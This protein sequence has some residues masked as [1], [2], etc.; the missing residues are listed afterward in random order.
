MFWKAFRGISG[1]LGKSSRFCAPL[2]PQSTAKN[3]IGLFHRPLPG[4]NRSSRG[5]LEVTIR[6]VVMMRIITKSRSFSSRSAGYFTGLLI[7]LVSGAASARTKPPA[8]PIMTLDDG[9]QLVNLARSGMAEFIKSRTPADK[10]TLPPEMKHL[11]TRFRPVSITLRSSGKLMA[12]SIRAD[13]NV[14]RSVLAAALDA[15]RSS[16]LPDRVTPAVLAA[17]TVEIEVLGPARAVS[18][19]ELGACIV[20]GLTGVRVSRGA[21]KK[22]VLPSTTCQLGLSALQTHVSCLA[23]LP[24]P[25]G[26]KAKA[27]AWSVFGSKHY[28]GYPDAVVVQLFRGKILIPPEGL[29]DE[30]LS[31]A[32]A[33]AGLF[34]AR[35]QDPNGMYNMPNRKP[36]LHEHLHATYAMA[37]LSRRDS[38]KLF[39]VSVNRAMAY[40]ARFVLADKKQARVLARSSPGRTAES[41]TRATAWLLLAI[42]ELPAQAANKE[43]A[44]KLARALRQDVVSV[45]GPDHGLTTPGQLLD[46]SVALM[47]LRR[48]LPKNESNAKLLDPMRKTMRAWSKSGQKLS[49]L[50]FRGTGTM[51]SLPK[52]R[53]IDDSDLPDRRGGFVSSGVE[54]TT[55][56]TAIAA[57]CLAEAIESAG[58]SPDDKAAINK[59][60]LR[61]RKFCYQMLYRSREAYWTAKPVEMIGGLRISPS[62]A[63]VSLEACAAAIEAFLL[64]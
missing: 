52:W 21:A 24:E 37:K 61:A 42:I 23:K 15:M 8:A 49:P 45:V 20:P 1:P 47:A 46:W 3:T 41:P 55:L 11:T 60:I 14:C 53:Q 16:N 39:S 26:G 5:L 51:T 35:G 62:A 17:M 7:A 4:Y 19:R 22:Y 29:T 30:V 6:T 36:A 18:S 44:E 54:P 58:A 64:K 10:Y 43:L 40:A 56:D 33:T 27:E 28:V 38:R 59:Q 63:T 57:V 9:K 13:T 31:S 34:L 50:V 32:A 12:R 2:R 48:F 25:P